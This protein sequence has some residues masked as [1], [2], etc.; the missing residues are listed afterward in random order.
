MRFTILSRT[1]I[2][3]LDMIDNLQVDAGIS[4]L[5]N[6]PLGR[7]TTVPLYREE[8]HCV[9]A[10]SHPLAGARRRSAGRSWPGCRSAC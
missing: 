7:V 3:I 4:Y 8:Y 10:T 5:D 6:E 9:C 2:E 1:S